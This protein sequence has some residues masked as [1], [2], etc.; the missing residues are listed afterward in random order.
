MALKR[1]DAGCRLSY[2]LLADGP[3]QT[4]DFRPAHDE[5]MWYARRDALARCANHGLWAFRGAAGPVVDEL[6]M[7][8]IRAPPR[9][10]IRLPCPGPGAA[11][12]RA[13][14]RRAAARLRSVF[15]RGD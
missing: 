13:R 2:L 3:A 6:S 9:R 11:G 14:A 4:Q 5:K 12:Q 1:D 8:R 15:R 10:P 7:V